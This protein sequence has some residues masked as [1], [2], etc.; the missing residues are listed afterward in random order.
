[1]EIINYPQ[2]SIEWYERRLGSIGGS[3]IAS[4]CSKGQGKMRKNLMYRLAGEILSGQSY[5]G[6]KNYHMDRGIEEEA[7]AINTYI[8]VTGNEIESVGLVKESKHKHCSPDGWINPNGILEVKCVIPSVHCEIIYQN[9]IPSEYRKQCQW[10]LFICQCDY[11]DF[12][13]YSPFVLEKPIWIIRRGRDE[14]LIKEMDEEAD[15]FISELDDL[16]KRIKEA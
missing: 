3:S 14:E 2:R 6:Y 5:D 11:V 15:K 1:M 10:G 13:S 7:D 8:A 16:I 9:E 4:V 12:V